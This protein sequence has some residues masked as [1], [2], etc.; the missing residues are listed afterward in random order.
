MEARNETYELFD[1][2]IMIDGDEGIRFDVN[3]EGNEDIGVIGPHVNIFSGENNNGNHILLGTIKFK[4]LGNL[5]M[6]QE[7]L[8]KI[9][10]AMMLEETE[11]ENRQEE[12]D[13]KKKSGCGCEIPG[14]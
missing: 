13:R 9:E 5:A 7:G 12:D 4:S 14:L 1:A 6:F 10:Q 8:D 3:L 2:H 11:E